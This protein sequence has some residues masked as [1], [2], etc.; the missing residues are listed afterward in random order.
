M[1]IKKA[2]SYTAIGF[3][4]TLIDINLTMN[5]QSVSVTPDF[6][7]WILF[8]LADDKYGTFMRGKEYLKWC[9]LI[10]A[11]IRAFQWVVTVFQLSVE[12]PGVVTIIIGIAEAV[13]MFLFFGVIEEVTRNYDPDRASTVNLLKIINLV[14]LL[15]LTLLGVQAL[16]QMSVALAVLVAVLGIAALVAAIVTCVVLFKIRKTVMSAQ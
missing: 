12:L 3:L 9:F 8:F 16:M 5:G 10:I 11:V 1:D 15:A 2:L 13:I 7:G 14:L 4:L 6:I